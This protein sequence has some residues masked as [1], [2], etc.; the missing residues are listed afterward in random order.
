M[1]AQKFDKWLILQLFI[2]AVI[3]FVTPFTHAD[4]LNKA[5]IFAD[6]LFLIGLLA[7]TISFLQLGSS[8]TPFVVPVKQGKL[9]TTGIYR[10]VRHPMYGGLVLLALGWT[11]HWTSILGL[12]LAIA[13]FFVLDQKASQ[14]ERWLSL[15]YPA[16]RNYQKQ[17]KKI[18]PF[19]Y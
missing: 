11:I 9:V 7:I 13:L 10:L 4:W 18:I 12:V 6:L 16:Y 1:R 17:V 15:K 5:K 8:F 14:E 3:L 2:F 19:I